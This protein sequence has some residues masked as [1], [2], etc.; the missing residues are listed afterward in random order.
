M[1][2]TPL[3]IASRAWLTLCFIVF[4]AGSGWAANSPVYKCFDKNLGLVY[5]DEP[6]KDGERLNIRA[7]DADPTAVARLER[8]ADALDQSADQRIADQ[9]RSAAAGELTSQFPSQPFDQG[10]TYDNLPLY[11]G[12]YGFLSY[13]GMHRRP[14]RP[15]KP[16]LRHV[17]HFAPRPP[18]VVPR[19]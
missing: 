7:G 3:S 19:R 9:R 16:S 18:F 8:Q 12:D 14:M 1:R 5:T 11:M 10:G 15:R 13:P 6:C 17:R 2:T 4:T